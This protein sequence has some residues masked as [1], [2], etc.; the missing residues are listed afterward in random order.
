MSDDSP[1]YHEQLLAL[2]ANIDEELDADADE[3]TPQET[4]YM[5]D[6][7]ER[8]EIAIHYRQLLASELFGNKTKASQIVQEEVRDFIRRRARKLVGIRSEEEKKAPPPFSPIQITALQMWADGLLRKQDAGA[9]EK[10]ARPSIP[11]TI[12]V[13]TVLPTA[14]AAPRALAPQPVTA[15]PQAAPAEP[16]KRPGRKPKGAAKEAPTVQSVPGLPRNVATLNG[17]IPF[18]SDA[19]RLSMQQTAEEKG[20][21]Y[22]IL[23]PKVG[24]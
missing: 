10:A 8:I 6:V 15:A 23:E 1:N 24:G 17:Y 12:D 4:E 22:E 18:P 19:V 9:S 2:G 3:P 14:V 20:S 5:G 7:D 16:A 13:P 21:V 11:R